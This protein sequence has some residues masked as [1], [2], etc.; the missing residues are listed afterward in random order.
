MQPG[1]AKVARTQEERTSATR[2]RL[3]EATLDLLLSKGY[4]AA[5]TVDIAARAGLTRG[6]LA[7]HFASKDELV[8]EAVDH[9]LNRTIAEI[10]VYASL[11]GRGSLSIADFVDRMW[12]IFS[13]PFFMVTLEHI[14]ASRHND[15]LKSRLVERTREF[16][17]SLDAIWRQ[18]FSE[19][20][21][22]TLEVETTFNA[23][24]CLLRGMGVQTV[25]R[26]DPVYYRRLLQ[27]WKSMLTEQIAASNGAAR[28][29]LR[30]S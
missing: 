18:F 17:K 26:N 1:V 28:Q 25:L 29:P 27:F 15:F 11:V 8:V 4:P 10:R 9:M 2:A 7:H 30:K 22:G 16:H 23:T 24:L 12:I 3:I 20:Q 13:G 14:T 21:I 6:A 5:T 19:T